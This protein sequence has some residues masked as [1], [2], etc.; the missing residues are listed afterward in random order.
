MVGPGLDSIFDLTRESK[1]K[2]KALE[3]AVGT[4][5]VRLYE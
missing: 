5:H 4:K 1:N 2:D 3:N